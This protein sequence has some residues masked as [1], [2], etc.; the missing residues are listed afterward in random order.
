MGHG[1]NRVKLA[2]RSPV[3]QANG[4]KC[5][6]CGLI[7]SQQHPTLQCKYGQ[8]VAILANARTEQ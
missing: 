1:R 8:L 3:E 2:S 6:Q 7:D 5:E 4:A